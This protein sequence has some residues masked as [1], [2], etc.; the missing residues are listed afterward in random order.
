MRLLPVAVSMA[1][2]FYGLGVASALGFA[3]LLQRLAELLE[4]VRQHVR[5]HLHLRRELVR[6]LR[7]TAV[8][9]VFDVVRNA[10]NRIAVALG[11]DEAHVA[12]GVEYFAVEADGALTY[13]LPVPG[14]SES[15]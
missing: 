14:I 6:G 1:G 5:H 8:E 12:D 3:V 7:V 10:A 15:V 13:G 2:P 9:L 11:A 4:A